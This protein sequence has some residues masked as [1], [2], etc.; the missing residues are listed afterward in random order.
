MSSTAPGRPCWLHD[1]ALTWHHTPYRTTS[2]DDL[3]AFLWGGR[4][5]Q[6]TSFG[7]AHNE[8]LARMRTASAPLRVNV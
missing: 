7:E 5:E 2:R 3:G 4:E 8:A 6:T 1:L